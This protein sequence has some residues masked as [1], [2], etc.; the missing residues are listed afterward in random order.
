[1]CQQKLRI[2][3]KLIQAGALFV[4]TNPDKSFPVEDGT[5]PGNG[6][7]I[8]ALEAASSQTATCIGKPN[9]IMFQLAIKRFNM[10]NESIAM[11]GDRLE[12]DILGAKNAGIKSILVLSGITK[13]SG[14]ANK[15]KPDMI[16]DH[17]GQLTSDWK[18]QLQ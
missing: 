14:Q 3:H 15:I 1:M 5:A 11:I 2:A 12:T 13:T 17:I 4:G 16:F 6:A 8:A 7:I 18:S 10:P 9:S